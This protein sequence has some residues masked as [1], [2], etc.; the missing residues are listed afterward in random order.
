VSGSVDLLAASTAAETPLGERAGMLVSAR[1]LHDLG[2][3]PLGARP[4]G[5]QDFLVSL[6]AEPAA[7]QT[8]TATGFWN[9]ESVRLDFDQSPGDAV[10]SNRA[11]SLG[12]GFDVG[13]ARME[14]TLGGSGYDA[15]LPLQP[16][17]QPGQ[18]PPPALRAS[19]ATDR[20]RAVA[21]TLWGAAESPMRAGVSLERIE[22]TYEARNSSSSAT[23][24]AWTSTGGAFIDATR[25]LGP[26]VTLRAGLRA[27]V[28]GGEGLRFA[29]RAALSWDV[30][31]E[32]LLTVAA[33]RYHQPTRSTD[34]EVERTLAEVAEAGLRPVELLPVATADHV[35]LSLDQRLGGAVALGLEGFW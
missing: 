19:A 18:A 2:R 15:E 13:D 33:G 11:A 4:Y 5:Y 16:S 34:F 35:V 14:I 24:Q 10:W 9:R 8:L 32:A 7:G 26:G 30:G 23:S 25:P 28:F 22:A 20:L 21:E 29:P 1:T 3:V 17:A 27:D 31:P 12:Y 6:D